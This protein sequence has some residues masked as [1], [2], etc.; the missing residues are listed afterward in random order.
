MGP[1]VR[2]GVTLERTPELPVALLAV[3]EAG[4]AYVPLDPAYPAA[5]LAAMVEDARAGQQG[6][7]LLTQERL[8]PR[9][10]A[11]L[12]GLDAP[13]VHLLCLDAEVGAGADETSEEGPLPSAV[14]P[15]NLAYLIYTSGSTGRPKGVAITHRSAAALL[16]WARTLFPPEDLAGVFASTSINF[17]L[18]VFE[19]FVPLAGGGTVVLG[20][21]ALALA[22][23]P[24][25]AR[26]TLVNTVPSAM[27]ELVRL[28]AVPPTVRTVNLAG[29][30]LRGALARRLYELPHVE[31]VLNLYGP[32]ED[33]TYSTVALA[34]RHGEPTIG[35]PVTGTR[36][37]V[38]DRWGRP[39][40]VGVPGELLLGGEGLARGYLHRPDLTAERWVPDPF[41]GAAGAR[42]YRTGDL[43]RWLSAGELEFLGRIDY[44]VKVRGFRIEMGE[45]EAAL[46]AHPAV[47]ESVV[48][49][50]EAPP[51][52]GALAG[53]KR[54]V[55]Y[56]V[57]A[58]GAVAGPE[59]VAALRSELARHLPDYMVPSAWVT[60]ERLPLNANGKVDRAALPEP[61]PAVGA[62]TADAA[63]RTPLEELLAQVWEELL[64]VRGVARSDSFFDLGGHSLLAMRVVSRLRELLAVEVPL[65]ALFEEPTV[66]GLAAKVEALRAAALGT[67]VPPLGRRRRDGRP[68]ASFA[69]ERFWFLEQMEGQGAVYNVPAALAMDGPLEV[70]ALA[71]ALAVLVGRHEALRTSFAEEGGRVVQIVAPELPIALPLVDLSALGAPAAGEARR[72]SAAAAARPFDLARGP[73]LRALLLRLPARHLLHL[74]LHHVACDGWSMGV[75]FGELAELYGAAAGSR[76]AAL[77]PLPIQYADFAAWQREW[78]EG[79]ALEAQLGFWRAALAGCRRS[80][81]CPPTGRARRPAASAAAGAARCCRRRWPRERRRSAGGTARRSS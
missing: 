25:A 71:A 50:R 61:G 28:G 42:L 30:P 14:D 57:P 48:L 4:G 23:S 41:S 38:V 40:P 56:V 9:I 10:E 18:S 53:E 51:A 55:A 34:P 16:A 8:V 73:V 70:P 78:L 64:A 74:C 52:A 20:D 36:A 17:D 72:L 81:S 13:P 1:E 67:A 79:P 35:V 33:T 43:A 29:E 19:L 66:A 27:A 22:G 75:F 21:D 58:E 39:A 60:L 68:P 59:L 47:R 11:A 5:R 54:L 2:V 65:R 45:V 15:D 80:S 46:A 26:V 6:F 31:R 69:Q 12:G 49:A 77:A 76:P 32:S 7:V 63:P 62:A 37:Y 44:Q 24:L 3:L